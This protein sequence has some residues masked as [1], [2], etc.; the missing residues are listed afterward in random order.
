M[1]KYVTILVSGLV[2]GGVYILLDFLIS[3]ELDIAMS[4][5]ATVVYV[6]LSLLL[7]G[8]QKKFIKKK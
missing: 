7:S 4:V 2:F 8:L 3:D 6:V 5:T 1:S